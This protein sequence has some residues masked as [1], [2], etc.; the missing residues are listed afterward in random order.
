MIGR[1]MISRRRFLC[2]VSLSVLPDRL[3]AEAQPTA[4]A[5]RIGFIGGTAEGIR[6]ARS[7]AFAKGLGELG[8]TIGRNVTIEYRWLGDRLSPAPE[9]VADF[10]RTNVDVIVAFGTPAV[11]SAKEATKSIPI[12][13][14]GPRD[15]V[16]QGMIASLARPGGNITGIS[17]TA[18]DPGLAAGKRLALIKEALPRASRVGHLW[19]S[20]FPGAK[21]GLNET[22]RTAEKLKITVRS[23]DVAGPDELSGAFAT[24]KREGVEAVSVEAALGVYRKRIIE[25]AAASRLPAMYGASVF[26]EEGGLMGY[27]PDWI[28]IFWKAGRYTGQVLN[29]AKP[30]DLPVE[31][32]TK[33]EFLVNLK[34]AKA[35]GFTIPPS[36]LVRADR[37]IE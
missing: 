22:Q 35:L 2:I 33:F 34:A 32:P 9:I 12:V 6:G 30:A 17:S 36:L 27:S 21:P 15:P 3:T 23:V 5:R 4:S 26:V 37:V 25:L 1:P 29:S 18:A 11:F 13:M 8:F 28:E 20:K 16:E 14:G 24:M 7:D 19:S 10:V 31:Q